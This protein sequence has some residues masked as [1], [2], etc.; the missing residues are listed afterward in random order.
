MDQ[1]RE[2]K[3]D[4]FTARYNVHRLIY[5]ERYCWIDQ[6]IAREKQLKGWRRDKKIRL[7]RAANPSLEDM[8]DYGTLVFGDSY[9]AKIARKH[10]RIVFDPAKERSF[11]EDRG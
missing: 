6:A 5:C 9:I 7:A 10:L 4:A 2:G 8:R 11:G 3:G 1:H